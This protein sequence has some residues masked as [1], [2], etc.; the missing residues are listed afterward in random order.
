[1]NDD[2]GKGRASAVPNESLKDGASDAPNQMSAFSKIISSAAGLAGSAISVPS[3]K[4]VNDA[5]GAYLGESGKSR[6]ASTSNSTSSWAESSNSGGR[7]NRSGAPE[8]ARLRNGHEELHVLHMESEFSLFLDGFASSPT[9]DGIG[10]LMPPQDLPPSLEQELSTNAGV[11]RFAPTQGDFVRRAVR[12]PQTTSDHVD[13]QRNANCTVQEQERLDGVEVLAILNGPSVM[14]ENIGSN[15]DLDNYDLRLTAEQMSKIRSITD[16]ILPPAQMHTAP[17]PGHPL[18]LRPNL[19]VFPAAVS[20]FDYD[21]SVPIDPENEAR[22]TWLAF[23]DQWDNVLAA[24]T[25]EVW[26]N[27]L[28]LV[29][30]ARQ[31]IE[32]FVDGRDV[33]ET[34]MALRRLGLILSHFRR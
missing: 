33:P 15:E 29:K 20:T 34:P 4:E 18:N 9:F 23:M 16:K 12:A 28:P 26:G 8:P 13:R 5:H 31:E 27:L 30:E 25:D 24:Y 6:P 19:N 2:K 11:D 10:P 7:I 3:S 32:T 21:L 22:N 1:M 17:A 14:D